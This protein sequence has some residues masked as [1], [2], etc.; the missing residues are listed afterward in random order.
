M[1]TL[2]E[3]ESKTYKNAVKTLDII[4]RQISMCNYGAITDKTALDKIKTA[5]EDYKQHE[6]VQMK[7]FMPAEE[8]K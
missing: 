6:R 5:M 3:F 4:G 2:S 8:E 1:T 7:M